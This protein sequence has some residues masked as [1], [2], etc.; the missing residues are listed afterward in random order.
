MY[1]GKAFQSAGP[2]FGN[3]RLLKR[4]RVAIL[5]AWVAIQI[6]VAKTFWAGRQESL[7]SIVVEFLI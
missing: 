7:Y 5:N 1:P 3:V 2:D 6:C 4:F